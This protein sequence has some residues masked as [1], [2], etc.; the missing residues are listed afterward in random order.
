M[1]LLHE[2]EAAA[3]ASRSPRR[4]ARARFRPERVA[5]IVP[6]VLLITA[7]FIVPILWSVYVSFTNTGLAGV[8]AA[9]PQWV[10]LDN[11]LALVSDPA[12]HEA[13][14]RTLIYVVFVVAGQNL[15]GLALALALRKRNRVIKAA[16]TAVVVCAWVIPE[17]VVALLWSAFLAP[18]GGTLSIL[19][20]LFA[21]P[22]P[23]LLVSAPMAAIVIASIWRGAAFSLLV[24]SA[25]LED[26]PLETLEAAQV[27]GTT[28]LQRLFYVILPTI[29]RMILTNLLLTTL[30][31]LG[32]FG[33]IYALTKGGPS[34]QT[35]TLPLFMYDQA[36]SYNLLGYGSAIALV[37]VL[38]GAVISAGYLLAFRRQEK[39]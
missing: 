35:E 12:A 38:L 30:Q 29:R 20:G 34:H 8:T 27:D 7:F 17:I 39:L 25:A 10:G 2:R 13:V 14:A 16:T 32:V 19:A 9:R 4:P 3:P 18:D 24:Y 31:T 22:N 5:L 1:Q 11:Y 33:L 36:F 28:A 15:V 26:V 23:E 21:L 37:I 6:A